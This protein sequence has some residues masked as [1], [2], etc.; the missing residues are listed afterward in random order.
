MGQARDETLAERFFGC[1]RHHHRLGDGALVFDSVLDCCAVPVRRIR[2]TRDTR[3]S[4]E[5]FVVV[6]GMIGL[7]TVCAGRDQPCLGLAEGGMAWKKPCPAAAAAVV[8]SVSSFRFR[9]A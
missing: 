8:M 7:R 9:L 4:R 3:P 6:G 2:Q 1:R 5:M